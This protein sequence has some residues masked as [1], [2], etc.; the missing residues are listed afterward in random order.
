[1]LSGSKNTVGWLP[2]GKAKLSLE[3]GLR[4]NRCHDPHPLLLAQW[5]GGDQQ[6]GVRGKPDPTGPA[7]EAACTQYG[8]EDGEEAT[9][10]GTSEAGRPGT[11]P[12]DLQVHTGGRSGSEAST[13]KE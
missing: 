9:S 6:A 5:G 3:M 12:R 10:S 1:M 2:G 11:R 4:T 13:S 7:E 8:K